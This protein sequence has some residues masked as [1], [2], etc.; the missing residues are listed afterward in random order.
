M[1]SAG[2]WTQQVSDT[3]V[4]TNNIVPFCAAAREKNR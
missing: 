3:K 1:F 2:F 4:K